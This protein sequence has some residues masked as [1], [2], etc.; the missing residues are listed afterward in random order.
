M[1]VPQVKEQLKQMMNASDRKPVEA[2]EKEGNA[3]EEIRRRAAYIKDVRIALVDDAGHMLQHDQP[4]V[5]AGLIDGFL[6]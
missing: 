6:V 2:E 5:V 1:I 3:Q 4:E